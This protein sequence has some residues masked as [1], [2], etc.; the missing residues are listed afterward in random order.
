MTWKLASNMRK[1]HFFLEGRSLCGRWGDLGLNPCTTQ[2]TGPTPGPDDCRACH[3]MVLKRKARAEE[4]AKQD[5]LDANPV[6]ECGPERGHRFGT[7]GTKT[8]ADTMKGIIG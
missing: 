6:V 1:A 4:K 7:N 5:I 2:E 3:R 8:R